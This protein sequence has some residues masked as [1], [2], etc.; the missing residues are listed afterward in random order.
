MFPLLYHEKRG[1]SYTRSEST[2]GGTVPSDTLHHLLAINGLHGQSRT[3]SRIDLGLG[4][5]DER[6]VFNSAYRM[7]SRGTSCGMGGERWCDT[8]GEWGNG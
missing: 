1:S 3:A 7:E 6:A 4:P 5:T 2:R 8:A